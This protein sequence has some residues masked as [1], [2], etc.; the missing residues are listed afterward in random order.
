[1]LT[2]CLRLSGSSFSLA[3]FNAAFC[4]SS[5]ADIKLRWE[6]GKAPSDRQNEN[7]SLLHR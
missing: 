3:S 2:R 7:L 6:S 4:S 1:M 5:W